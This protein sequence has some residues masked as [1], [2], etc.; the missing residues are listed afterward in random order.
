[1]NILEHYII[2]VHQVIE[3]ENF[4]NMIKVDLTYEC[5]GSKQRT[6]HTTTKE[7]WKKELTQGYY[8]E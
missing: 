5:W 4:P 1:M 6:W 3:L 2:E 8:L 7:F